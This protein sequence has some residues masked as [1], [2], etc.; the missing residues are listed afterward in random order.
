V[1]VGVEAGAEQSLRHGKPPEGRKLLWKSIPPAGGTT[2]RG[3]RDSDGG[4]TVRDVVAHGSR[5]ERPRAAAGLSSA[6]RRR[7]IDDQQHCALATWP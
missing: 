4:G 3:I 7:K 1:V 5:G 6:R 2:A